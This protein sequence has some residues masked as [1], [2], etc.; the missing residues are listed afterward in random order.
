MSTPLRRPLPA[1]IA[2]LALLLLTGLVWWRVLHRDSTSGAAS[3]CVTQSPT[4]PTL[5]AP[6]LI[7]LK[8][9]NATDRNGIASKART[10]LAS[11]GFNIPNAA[12]NDNPKVK[13]PGVAEIRYGPRGRDGALLV[14]YFLPG[15]KLVATHSKTATVVISLGE[16]YRGV[17]SPSSV[18]AALKRQQVALDTTTPG[19]PSPSPSC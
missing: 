9:L 11:D 13:I 7:T 14:H 12:A 10:T 2:L 5:P 19:A 8:V 15:A 16:R 3:N 1:L 4:G 18:Q 6:G 17:A